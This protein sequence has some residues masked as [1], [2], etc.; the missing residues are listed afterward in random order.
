MQEMLHVYAIEFSGFIFALLCSAPTLS[1][2]RRTPDNTATENELIR[3]DFM[4]KPYIVVFVFAF[5]VS[6][7]RHIGM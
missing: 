7:A 5:R 6:R 4:S 1:A 2:T 3:S